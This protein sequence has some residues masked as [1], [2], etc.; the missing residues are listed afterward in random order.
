MRKSVGRG[1]GRSGFF[2]PGSG[3]ASRLLDNFENGL[4]TFSRGEGAQQ[5][6]DGTHG[7]TAFSDD[8][9][10]V[11]LIAPQFVDRR[12]VA[13]DFRQLDGFGVIDDFDNDLI[14]F[15]LSH[16][17]KHHQSGNSQNAFRDTLGHQ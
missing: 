14:F 9:A 2:H 3:P 6:A 7:F 1:P 17:F 8:L 11:F 5:G 12:F 16:H 13:M 10:Q 4:A 15:T